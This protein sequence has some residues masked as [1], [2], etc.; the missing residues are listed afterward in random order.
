M[1]D[2]LRW[3]VI[4][5]DQICQHSFFKILDEDSVV[6]DFGANGGVFSHAIIRRYGCRVFSAEPVP[7]LVRKID[8]HRFLTLLPVAISDRNGT[9]RINIYPDRCP[10]AFDRHD[11]EQRSQAVDVETVT[12]QEFRRRCG[13]EAVD[14]LK[15]DIEGSELDVFLSANPEEL[16]N[17]RQISVEFHSFIYPDTLERVEAVKERMRKIG[18]HI[19]DFSLNNTDVLFINRGSPIGPQH[20]LWAAAV[21]YC[22]GIRR[23]LRRLVGHRA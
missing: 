17:I 15:V 2:L 1:L 19:M 6:V 23:R 10:S 5:I 3:S 8:R 13:I 11:G 16:L 4:G 9:M 14:L 7:D 20:M 21:K 22:R 18:F 12:L